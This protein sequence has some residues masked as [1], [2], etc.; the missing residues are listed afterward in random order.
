MTKIVYNIFFPVC[1]LAI[2]LT[3]C[4]EDE[5]VAP[6]PE[7]VPLT[8]TVNNQ[9]FVMGD[10]LVV[11]FKVDGEGLVANEDF[12][13]Y[14]TAKAGDTD[15]SGVFE[16]FPQMVTFKKGE[17]NLQVDLP[18][19]ETGITSD[20]TFDLSAFARGY[21]MAGSIQSILVSDYYRTVVSM[22]GNADKVVKEG[23]TFVIVAK[24]PV[25]V[26]EEVVVNI[27]PKAG[28][29]DWYENLPAS[30]T[31]PAGET[32]VESEAVKIKEDGIPTGDK[33]LTLIFRTPSAKYPLMEREMT[34]KMKD[35]DEPLG[36]KLQDERWIYSNP[37]IPFVSAG[38][39]AK[40]EAWYDKKIQEIA[41]GE[42]HP[43][44]D[45][46]ANQWKFWRAYEFHK[47]AHSMYVKKKSLD[48]SVETAFYPNIFANQNTQAIQTY[49]AVDNVKCA[50]ITDEG[51]LRMI[52][53]KEEATA[54]P[55]DNVNY[56]QNKHFLTSAFYANKFNWNNT[57]NHGFMPMNVRIFPGMRIEVRTRLRGAL[58]GILPGIWLQGNA[59][60]LNWPTYGEIDML[61]NASWN[62][63]KQKLAEQTFHVNK[64]SAGGVSAGHYNP[65]KAS[66][67]NHIDEWNIY[68]M[69]W[70][71]ENSVTLGINGEA[72]ITI[73]RSEVT[74]KGFDWPFDKTMNPEGLHFLLTMMFQKGNLPGKD[75][76]D[77]ID[78]ASGF[79]AITYSTNEQ[80]ANTPRMEIDWVRFYTNDNYSVGDKNYNKNLYY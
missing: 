5:E 42:P 75:N 30:I 32:T 54:T 68:W 1:L 80:N 9:S 60:N 74:D 72:R 76:W 13:I 45:L 29:A 21:R 27:E 19:V 44:K 43:N 62:G 63:G 53:L 52:T 7:A 71:D 61:E 38:T 65:T 40:V 70:P 12:D 46:A 17:S 49:G 56:P 69:E 50:S 16:A 37:A 10:H 58:N 64:V 26:T 59:Q 73:T 48:N 51:Y 2:G 78:W 31:I 28:E 22:K 34:V 57:N 6:L 79:S 25:A 33:E 41:P 36:D 47:I 23:E 11:D 55:N 66:T 8:M 39:K 4:K 14:L 67:L 35:Q 18:I 20:V 15:Q 24:V 3:G 77:N